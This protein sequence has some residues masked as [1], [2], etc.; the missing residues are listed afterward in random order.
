MQELDKLYEL[1]GNIESEA[2]QEYLCKPLRKEQDRL[3]NAYD[4]KSLTEL[5]TVKG[6]KQGIDLFFKQL[7]YVNTRIDDLK[8]EIEDSE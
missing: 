7:E 5:A 4:C 3:K 2:F 6:K 1:K 8:T